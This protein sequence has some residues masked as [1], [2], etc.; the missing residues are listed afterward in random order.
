MKF[1]VNVLHVKRDVVRGKHYFFNVL[2][3]EL[4][5][6]FTYFI[7]SFLCK[8]GNVVFLRYT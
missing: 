4:V 3:S 8:K 1:W 5:M 2:F 6:P 7:I